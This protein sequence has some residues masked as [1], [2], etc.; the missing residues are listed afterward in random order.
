LRIFPPYFLGL[1]VYLAVSIVLGKPGAWWMWLSYVFYYASLIKFQPAS[2]LPG[3]AVGKGAA[4]GAGAV[5]TKDMPKF[6]IVAGRPDKQTGERRAASFE[7]R[8]GYCR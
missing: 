4:I 3:V 7:Y 6:A 2:L 5:A 8:A 1:F